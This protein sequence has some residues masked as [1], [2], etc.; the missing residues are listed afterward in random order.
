MT[1]DKDVIELRVRYHQ[2]GR[3]T[4]TEKRGSEM[5]TDLTGPLF[6][7]TDKA[8]FYRAVAR[9]IA[10]IATTG[11]RVTYEDTKSGGG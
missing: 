2:S 7:N 5:P 8:E 11:A 4:L 3:Y 1:Q 9:K 6:G 10:E